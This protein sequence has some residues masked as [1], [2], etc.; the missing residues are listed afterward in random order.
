MVNTL[1]TAEVSYF[2]DHSLPN[3]D[4]FRFEV[5]M[6]NS[7]DTHN[8]ERLHNLFKNSEDLLN[9]QL[10]IFLFVVLKKISLLAVLHDDF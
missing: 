1:G 6:E 2:D 4:I 7:L 10:L 5:S 8:Y 3:K 9:R